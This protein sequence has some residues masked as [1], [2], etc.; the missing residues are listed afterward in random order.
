MA[1]MRGDAGGAH[2]ADDVPA[3]LVILLQTSSWCQSALW[4]KVNQ[5]SK[6]A[7]SNQHSVRQHFRLKGYSMMRMVRCCEFASSSVLR[8]GWMF[9]WLNADC[10]IAECLK[11]HVKIEP[12]AA[13]V[14]AEEVAE[15]RI[16]RIGADSQRI[17]MIGQIQAAHRYPRRVLGSNGEILCQARVE[18]KILW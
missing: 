16:V 8:F 10:C 12:E 3:W 7:V 17:R 6:R 14:I 9:L 4:C 13:A 15:Q 18:R 11:Q 5:G 2:G 1:G